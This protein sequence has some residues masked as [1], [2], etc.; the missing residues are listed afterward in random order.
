MSKASLLRIRRTRD[1]ILIGKDKR[2]MLRAFDEIKRIGGGM[3]IAEDGGI[4]SQ[5]TDLQSAADFLQNRWR[6]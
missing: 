1:I 2:Q 5:V 3:V 6:H 4:R